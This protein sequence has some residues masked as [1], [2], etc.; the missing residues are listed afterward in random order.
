MACKVAI[1]T[2]GQPLHRSSMSH[3]S[4]M[5]RHLAEASEPGTAARLGRG[6]IIEASSGAPSQWTDASRVTIDDAVLRDSAEA[7]DT[8]H[9]YWSQ[10]TPVVVE[11]CCDVDEL[12]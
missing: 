5:I 1:R 11:L 9:R 3:R 8:L 7:L 12:R 4:G 10:R 6:V 2:P